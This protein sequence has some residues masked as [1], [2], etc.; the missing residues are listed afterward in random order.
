MIDNGSSL[1]AKLDVSIRAI[2]RDIMA[3][4]QAGVLIVAEEG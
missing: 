2:Y 1:A 4:E 3:L